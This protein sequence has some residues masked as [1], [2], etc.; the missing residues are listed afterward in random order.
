MHGPFAWICLGF[1]LLI[2]HQGC[3]QLC[4]SERV[5]LIFFLCN[6][7]GNSLLLPHESVG[8]LPFSNFWRIGVISCFNVWWNLNSETTSVACMLVHMCIFE[9]FLVQIQFTVGVWVYFVFRLSYSISWTNSSFY[10]CVYLN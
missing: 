7:F 9:R 4:L 8:K 6:V 1:K 10:Q 2:F 3:L 5:V